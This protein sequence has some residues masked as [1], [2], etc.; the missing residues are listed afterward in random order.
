[1]LRWSGPPRRVFISRRLSALSIH[2]DSAPLALIL[3]LTC[4]KRNKQ[5]CG[6]FREE[7]STHTFQMGNDDKSVA[8]SLF[9]IPAQRP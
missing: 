3:R 2:L 6:F 1:M 8:L 7:E 4:R 5:L 9:F